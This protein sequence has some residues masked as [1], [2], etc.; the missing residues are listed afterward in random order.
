MRGR[1]GLG[2]SAL[3]T[4]A[5]LAATG[6]AE[7]DT[8]EVT[9]TGDPA[10][11]NCTP[12]DCSLREA[13]GKANKTAGADAILLPNRR[14]PYRLTVAGTD[15]DL[16]ADGDLDVTGSALR[17]VH[18]GKGRATIDAEGLG[19]RHLQ[20]FAPVR[21]SKLILT[22]GIDSG[23]G[24][25]SSSE[26]LTISNSVLRGNESTN[27]GGAIDM[28]DDGRLHITD[29]VLRG[30]VAQN[31][32][33]AIR[34]GSGKVTILRS[35]L[36]GNQATFDGGAIRLSSSP[37]SIVRTRFARNETT[38][39]EGGAI[40]TDL[41][42]PL[43]IRKSTFDRNS[44]SGDGGALFAS[45]VEPLRIIASTLG[46]NRAGGNGG[47]LFVDGPSTTIENSTFSA[48]RAD[49]RGGGIHAQDGADVSLNAVTVARN[50]AAADD[51][52]LVLIGGGGLSRLSS[53][54][55]SVRN[56][57]IALNT[58]GAPMS[59]S[60]NDCVSDVPF[61][62][63]GNNLLSEE[64][65]GVECDGFD[66]PN[67]L[68]RANPKIGKLKRN[69]GPTETV[70]LKRGSAAIGNAHRPSAPNRDQ[71]GER[72]DSRPD[73]GAFER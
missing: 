9:R 8:F 34:D 37:G 39:A 43:V 41:E 29:S 2:A 35:K 72:R 51:E 4:A 18:P 1:L 19:E 67:D 61:D 17:I 42:G 55:F 20:A 47:G 56:S 33:G 63:L 14:N 13:V 65:S 66:G 31:T 46:R 54:G 21:L 15:E 71:R 60:R 24:A 40:Q 73:I 12:A 25:L 50:R 6:H 36:V 38:D 44:A 58:I 49:T 32:A 45:G 68:V 7:A 10:P 53:A 52:G 22:G 3:A 64:P 57:L 23:G 16:A 28:E 5:L 26:N 62:S 48:N 69:G 70:A 59:R 30:N 27:V 11:G